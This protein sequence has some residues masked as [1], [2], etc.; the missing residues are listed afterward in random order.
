[1]AYTKQRT[2]LDVIG[3]FLENHFLP[4]CPFSRGAVPL[5]VR[6]NDPPHRVQFIMDT[7]EDPRYGARLVRRSGI[8]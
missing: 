7:A 8:R 3:A 2:I 6:L 1:M 4:V 5:P